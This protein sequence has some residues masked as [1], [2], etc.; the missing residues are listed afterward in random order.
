MPI[1]PSKKMLPLDRIYERLVKHPDYASK[2]NELRDYPKLRENIETIFEHN[3]HVDPEKDFDWGYRIAN[4]RLVG[5]KKGESWK[6]TNDKNQDNLGSKRGVLE[7]LNELPDIVWPHVGFVEQIRKD[8][9]RQLYI[10]T[11][12][13]RFPS[14][15]Y[16]PALVK[17]DPEPDVVKNNADELVN[18]WKADFG[19]GYNSMKR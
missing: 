2:L 9:S 11:V 16:T 17:Y 6:F 1:K 13:K 3:K 19:D 18:E 8:G 12:K 15:E 7:Y 4:E 10:P 14:K 5:E